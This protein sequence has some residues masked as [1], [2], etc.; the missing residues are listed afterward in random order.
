MTRAKP[1]EESVASADRL[2][3]TR[4]QVSA[5]RRHL[6]AHGGEHQPGLGE[7][8]NHSVV[9]DADRPHAMPDDD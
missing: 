6:A 9:D 1:E 2:S 3:V 8:V 7:Q 4:D 5:R